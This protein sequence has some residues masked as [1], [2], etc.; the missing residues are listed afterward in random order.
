MNPGREYKRRCYAGTVDQSFTSLVFDRFD[1]QRP[2]TNTCLAKSD[3]VTG[4]LDN[5]VKTSAE[6]NYVARSS[7]VAEHQSGRTHQRLRRGAN[8]TERERAWTLH[9]YTDEP[10]GLAG[11]G[12]TKVVG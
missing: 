7:P 2:S 11:R 9:H 4:L 3:F 12:P 5:G 8:V 10:A 6:R 1:H